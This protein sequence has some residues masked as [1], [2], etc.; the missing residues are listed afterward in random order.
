M[1]RLVNFCE[2]CGIEIPDNNFS[3]KVTIDFGIRRVLWTSDCCPHCMSQLEQAVGLVI[4]RG[5]ET[6]LKRNQLNKSILPVTI[7]FHKELQ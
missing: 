7:D 3:N 2:V 1:K 5:R 4:N 6:V